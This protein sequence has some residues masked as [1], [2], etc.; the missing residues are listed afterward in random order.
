MKTY[1]V[2][3]HITDKVTLIS[4]DSDKDALINLYIL[5]NH[6]KEY[7]KC[8]SKRNYVSGLIV[9]NKDSLSVFNYYIKRG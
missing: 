7:L 4:A 1:E 8:E 2:I 9:E 6:G 3:Q 5:K